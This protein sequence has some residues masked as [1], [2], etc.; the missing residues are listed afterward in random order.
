VV[1]CDDSQVTYSVG[2]GAVLNAALG[3]V[4]VD[5]A[6]LAA[7]KIDSV[8][9]IHDKRKISFS[10]QEKQGDVDTDRWIEFEV[11]ELSYSLL[12]VRNATAHVPHSV[13]LFVANLVDGASITVTTT[14]FALWNI[15]PEAQRELTKLNNK[16]TGTEFDNV[17]DKFEESHVLFKLL[18][19]AGMVCEKAKEGSPTQPAPKRHKYRD[20]TLHFRKVEALS[21]VLANHA[22]E[23]ITTFSMIY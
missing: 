3:L 1:D 11:V 4:D 13:H 23:S 16:T 2:N 8:S 10:V 14:Y 20:E 18:V 15:T 5:G 22:I 12:P 17:T 21:V 9:Y 7:K 6:P 19:A